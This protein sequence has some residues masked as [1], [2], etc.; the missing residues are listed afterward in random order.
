LG[1]LSVRT[2][3]S[4]AKLTGKNTGK[5][6]D[7]AATD[8]SVLP[9]NALFIWL[10][11]NTGVWKSD[12]ITGNFMRGNRERISNNTVCWRKCHKKFSG[13]PPNFTAWKRLEPLRRLRQSARKSKER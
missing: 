1:G 7:Q 5:I 2:F 9:S 10:F 11:W 6:L 3:I 8:G 12:K 4:F 13:A